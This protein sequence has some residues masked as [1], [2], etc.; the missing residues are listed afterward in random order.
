[1]SQGNVSLGSLFPPCVS[2]VDSGFFPW[3]S[4]YAAVLWESRMADVGTFPSFEMAHGNAT[5]GK[6]MAWWPAAVTAVVF[7]D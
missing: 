6:Q 4:M 7:Q 3:P 1:M 5:Y 2:W